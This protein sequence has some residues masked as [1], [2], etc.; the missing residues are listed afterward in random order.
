M[1]GGPRTLLLCLLYVAVLLGGAVGLDRL[2][3]GRVFAHPTDYVPAYRAFPEYQV[4]EQIQQFKDQKGPFNAFFLGNS[5]TLFGVDPAAFDNRLA[6]RGVPYRAYNMAFV[7]VDPEIWPF[8][9]E[10]FYTGKVPRHVFLGILTRDLD[11]R[12]TSTRA[13]ITAFQSSAGFANRNLSTINAWTEERLARLFI[14][15]GRSDDARLLT[16]HNL[17]SGTPLDIHPIHL[18]GHLGQGRLPPDQHLPLAVKL[19]NQRKLANRHGPLRFELGPQ[20]QSILS[21][22]AYLNRH[23]SCLTLYTT[24]TLYDNEQWGTVEMRAGFYAALAR[25]LSAT[26]TIGFV[27]AARKLPAPLP[28]AD[29]GDGDHLNAQGAAAFS[30]DLA[31]LMRPTIS[32]RSCGT[33]VA[34]R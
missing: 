16:F 23:G 13:F 32:A 10:H 15:R 33:P 2:V 19:A 34:A 20:W 7:S 22:S 30:R 24:P 12:F 14:L 28:A 21:L 9:F 27:D 31:D 4:G 6:H 3:A 26:P 18:S 25:L 11:A 5:R 1:R 8:W 29:Y 17:V